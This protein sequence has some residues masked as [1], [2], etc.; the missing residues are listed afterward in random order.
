MTVTTQYGAARHMSDKSTRGIGDGLGIRRCAVTILPL[1]LALMIE[2]F[3][4]NFPFWESLGF[5]SSAPAAVTVGQGLRQ[6]GDA[7]T[8]VGE[9]E[10]YIQLDFDAPVDIR[11]IMIDLGDSGQG[12]QTVEAGLAVR[13]ESN[14]PQYADFGKAN[15]SNGLA[16]T[17]YIRLHPAGKIFSI[18]LDFGLSVG[19]SMTVH[20]ITVNQLRPFSISWLRTLLLITIMYAAAIF[21]PS[22]VIY[23][24]KLWLRSKYQ[25]LCLILFFVVQ[26]T[27]L[28]IAN[29]MSRPGKGFV[30]PE[31]GDYTITDRNQ[32]VHLADAL[33]QGH[34]YLDLPVPQWLREMDN[35]YSYIER[36]NLGQQT[37]QKSYF[38]YAFYNGKY[39][40][41]FGVLPAY[42]LYIPFKIITKHDLRT[43]WGVAFLSVLFVAAC[44]YFLYAL[45]KKYFTNTSLGAY[46]VGSVFLITASGVLNQVYA[47]S[48][49][50]I[51]TLSSSVFT[52]CGLGLW[53]KACENSVI[54]KLYL[55]GGALCIAA[56]LLCRPVLVVAV[57]FAFPI[58]WQEI[59]KRLFF[60]I[61]GIWNT[62]CV[63]IP[64][65]L[66]GCLAM[67]YNYIRFHS[68]FDFGAS[69]NLTG[70]DM[71]I[72]NHDFVKIVPSLWFFIFQPLKIQTSF[73]F[74]DR[75]SDSSFHGFFPMEP[76]YGGVLAFAPLVAF[77]FLLALKDVRRALR[78]QGVLG[79]ASLSLCL[80]GMIILYE[81]LMVSITMRYGMDF[82]WLLSIAALLVILCL[83]SSMDAESHYRILQA[84]VIVL[85]F[86]GVAVSY[87]N[88]F[89]LDR[90]D[91]LITHNPYLYRLVESWFLVFR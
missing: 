45:L 10:R 56:N 82:A 80:A 24:T 62:L 49:Y 53:L 57:L 78:K 23:R 86:V 75:V 54:S 81:A 39:Y 40:S 28:I 41:Y 29:Q 42:L 71:Q 76:F 55:T 19:Q 38:D 74:L 18:R 12:F 6:N 43:D 77:A 84:V 47:P 46:L 68:P 89:S 37:G 70:F 85:V 7:Y 8:A 13:D 25:I 15:V 58:F 65:I 34:P 32:Y 14:N 30:G 36:A 1:L 91:P 3:V 26:S 67:Y 35:P 2:L 27:I 5:P 83:S 72:Q 44:M 21:R 79:I 61:K 48:F 66:V 73:P 17:H 69:Y 31:I 11:N 51:P 87:L 63:F 22:S 90:Y 33:M 4:C 16:D 88:L 9:Q 64:F 20:A 52:L 59:R 50:M 60:S